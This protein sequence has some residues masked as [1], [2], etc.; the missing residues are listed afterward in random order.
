MEIRIRFVNGK[1]AQEYFSVSSGALTEPQLQ[2]ILSANAQGSQW[3]LQPGKKS[4][5]SGVRAELRKYTR[6]DGGAS[7]DYLKLPSS[8]TLAI[9]TPAIQRAI[10]EEGT[11]F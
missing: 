6:T 8:S 7:A 11:G 5:P 1:S 4:E 3:Q 9:E 2:E 10:N